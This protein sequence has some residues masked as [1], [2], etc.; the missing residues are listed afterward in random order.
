M[1]I[2]TTVKLGNW[3]YTL[4]GDVVADH[5]DTRSYIMIEGFE[6]S[7]LDNEDRLFNRVLTDDEVEMCE[8]ILVKEFD[9]C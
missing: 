9:R 8:D 3:D 7:G 4:I 2:E 6:V 1:K 5:D